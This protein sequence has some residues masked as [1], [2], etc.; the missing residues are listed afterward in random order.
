MSA[1]GLARN[2]GVSQG[3]AA[4]FIDQYFASYPEVKAWIAAT[5][6]RAAKDGYVTTLLNRRR[7]VADLTSSNVAMRKA[8]ERV[9]VNTPVQGSA[10]D[11]IKRAMVI[12]DRELC[13]TRARLILQVHDEL[14][15]EAPADE[16]EKVALTV[17][18]VMENACELSVPLKVDVGVGDNWAG[19][20]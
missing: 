10:A 9:A 11:I 12:L 18:N 3:E 8:A 16:A 13:G 14:V 17:K 19:I 15:V 20:H 6:D 2:L 4:R 7:Y 5:L 1:F